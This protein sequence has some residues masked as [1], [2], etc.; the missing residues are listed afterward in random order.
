VRVFVTGATGFV[1]SHLTRAL[2]DRGDEVVCLV[3]DVERAKRLLD[4]AVPEL[5]CGNLNDRDTLRSACSGVDVIFHSAALTTAR[6]RDGFFKVNADATKV[7]LEAAVESAPSLTRFVYVSSQAAA[8]PSQT[9]QPRTENEEPEPVSNYGAS[10][11]AGEENVRDSGLP[12]TIVRPCAVYGPGDRAFLTVF[13]MVRLGFM[14]VLGSTEQE[15]SM[16]HIA[17]LVSSLLRVVNANTLNQTYFVSNPEIVT[18]NTLCRQISSALSPGRSRRALVF[19]LPRWATRSILAVTHAAAGLAGK[20]TFLSPDK[21]HEYL[22]EA[23]VC[24]S[25][26]LEE[27]TGW[28]AEMSIG[29]GILDTA[30]WY[31]KNGWL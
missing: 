27:D 24:S 22:A 20:S 13:K 25:K 31:R 19:G 30:R 17:D 12:W 7:V 8:G 15:I 26:K 14:P 18:A 6:S 5:V 23:W 1:G 21:G 28:C 11:L 9:G 16:V 10:K 4:D 2:L 3:R 29:E